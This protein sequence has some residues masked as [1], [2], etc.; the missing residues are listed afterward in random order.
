MVP[1]MGNSRTSHLP[2]SGPQDSHVGGTGRSRLPKEGDETKDDNGN[3][4]GAQQSY[5]SKQA[6]QD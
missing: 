2:E 5:P 1:R 3:T 4:R 6:I